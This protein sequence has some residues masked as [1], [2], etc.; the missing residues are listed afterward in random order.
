[1]TDYALRVSPETDGLFFREG[2]APAEPRRD[3]SAT[4]VT[5]RSPAGTDPRDPVKFIGPVRSA[6]GSA[7]ASPSHS[8]PRLGGRGSGQTLTSFAHH[9]KRDGDHGLWISGRSEQP[10]GTVPYDE[11]ELVCPLL[12]RQCYTGSRLSMLRWGVWFAMRVGE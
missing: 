2:E 11:T 4:M 3:G 1:M 6:C 12:T 10:W 9:A 7:G 5:I 8:V